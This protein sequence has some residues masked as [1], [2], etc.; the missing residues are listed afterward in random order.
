[1]DF[2][3]LRGFAEKDYFGISGEITSVNLGYHGKYVRGISKVKSFVTNEKY[4]MFEWLNKILDGDF[5]DDM[6]FVP[7]GGVSFGIKFV[8][9]ESLLIFDNWDRPNLNPPYILEL[10][11]VYNDNYILST[12]K[13]SFNTVF[14]SYYGFPPL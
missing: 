1:M 4:P 7:N 5:Y 12:T 10:P 13:D 2:M 11:V 14:A 3:K 9:I 8:A 6:Y